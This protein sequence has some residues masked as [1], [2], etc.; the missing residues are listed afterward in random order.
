MPWLHVVFS[1]FRSTSQSGIC[2]YVIYT[3]IYRRYFFIELVGI[4]QIASWRIMYDVPLACLSWRCARHILFVLRIHVLAQTPSL[5]V[6]V[7]KSAMCDGVPL[8][9]TTTY[10]IPRLI[11]NW[12]RNSDLIWR[13]HKKVVLGLV[14]WLPKW[15]LPWTKHGVFS[16]RHLCPTMPYIIIFQV[17]MFI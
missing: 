10:R 8:L 4:K 16:S 2:S 1:G 3:D 12:V 13:H 5:V 6:A 7:Q 17:K 9:L 11:T 14:N 15:L